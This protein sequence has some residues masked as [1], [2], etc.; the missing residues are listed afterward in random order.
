[1]IKKLIAATSLALVAMSASAT[2]LD[3]LRGS[4]NIKLVGLTTEFNTYA[5]SNE[6]TWGVG[7]VTQIQG[8][9]GQ[10][11]NAHDSDGTYLYYMLYGIADQNIINTGPGAFDIYN[12]GA[13]GGVADGKIHLDVYRTTTKIDALDSNFNAAPGA[14]TGYNSYSLLAALGPAYLKLEFQPGKHI[15]NEVGGTNPGADETQATLVQQTTGANLP[16]DGKGSFFADVAGGTAASQWDT[17]GLT[18]GYDFDGKYTLST[19]G[20]TQGSGTCT[21]AQV[22]DGTCFTG[23]IN[24][25]IRAN[26]IP[27]PGSLA[28]FGLTLAGLAGARRRMSKKAK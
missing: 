14:R 9:G 27:E 22:R 25:P 1:M 13:S 8:T 16:A 3:A 7:S 23:L 12:I 20:E 26:K 6:T 24:D 28:L 18:N 21:D 17:N 4:L 11:W 5:A 15:V 2:P 19:N 10:L